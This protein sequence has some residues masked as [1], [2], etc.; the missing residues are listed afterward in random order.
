MAERTPKRQEI[1]LPFIAEIVMGMFALTASYLY[2]S[3][4]VV[5]LAPLVFV[6]IFVFRRNAWT[7]SAAI[8][9]SLAYDLYQRQRGE[10]FQIVLMLLV[11]GVVLQ[12]IA[13]LWQRY[14]LGYWGSSFSENA[15]FAVIG[16]LIGYWIQF[17]MCR[18]PVGE[19]NATGILYLW[20]ALVGC[21]A[22]IAMEPMATMTPSGFGIPQDIVLKPGMDQLSP[23]FLSTAGLVCLRA[24]LL[25]PGFWAM[26]LVGLRA[27]GMAIWNPRR[28]LRFTWYAFWGLQL[29][30]IPLFFF[31]LVLG[32]TSLLLTLEGN[33]SFNPW[34]D[35]L[36]LI[37]ILSALI[38]GPALGANRSG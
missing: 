1:K 38:I 31:L 37:A 36:A 33:T 17:Q 9:I 19:M 15:I 22:A 28:V 26:L 20:G 14:Q 21:T 12:M 6:A 18:P 23:L 3:D 24:F 27:S 25:T 8:L 10:E 34:L 2:F 13:A 30:G 16:L 35:M 7:L 11:A 4:R 5:W 29:V 32:A